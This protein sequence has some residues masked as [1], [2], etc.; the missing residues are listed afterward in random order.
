MTGWLFLS[1]RDAPVTAALP[2]LLDSATLVVELSWPLPT[3]VLLDWQGAEGQALSLF[4]HPSSGLGL[5]WRDGAV[6]RRFLLAGRLRSDARLARL[7]LRLSRPEE[8][9]SMRLDAGDETTI[10]S[11]YGLNPPAFRRGRWRSFAPG[12][13]C[14]GAMPRSC[15]SASRRG[16]C[17]R[18]G[19]PG[20][21]CRRP[22]PPSKG[23]CPRRC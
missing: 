16:R 9:W 12:A 13:G 18:A 19:G 10:A 8:T 17:R 5:L 20:S 4:H 2:D 3:G 22:F 7:H 14:G 23:W 15:G 1:D 11:T 6:L 21:G